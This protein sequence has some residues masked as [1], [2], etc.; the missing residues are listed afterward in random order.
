[1]MAIAMIAM[2][3]L[4]K[5]APFSTPTVS[6]RGNRR[7]VGRRINLSN[8]LLPIRRFHRHRRQGERRPTLS[9]FPPTLPPACLFFNLSLLL[10]LLPPPPPPA[11]IRHAPSRPNPSSAFVG[12]LRRSVEFGGTEITLR[13]FRKTAPTE[14]EREC[15]SI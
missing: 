5:T 8:I 9:A 15:P 14:R 6:E 13:N 12:I 7:S 11:S 1:M 2:K 10:P 3:W 4:R